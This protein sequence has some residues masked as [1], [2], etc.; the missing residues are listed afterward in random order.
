MAKTKYGALSVL[1]VML[2]AGA[3]PAL[4]QQ[5][6]DAGKTP[7]QL[8]ASDCTFC[9]KTPAGLAKSAGMFGVERFLREHYTSSR[10]SAAAIARYLES[11]KEAPA[12]RPSA[13]R[14]KSE[15]RAK[16]SDDKPG[17]SESK[18]PER[19][20]PDSKKPAAE[21]NS[22]ASEKPAETKPVEEKSGA[23]AASQ[24]EKPATDATSPGA[25]E[26]PPEKKGD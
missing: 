22:A 24:S 10:Q 12:A 5:D 17:N 1:A 7:A 26:K 2:S 21:K 19:K 18:K 3:G 9:H 14:P 23:G 8:F 11:F 20:K 6:Y 13:R 4:A 15:Q 16:G 25:Q